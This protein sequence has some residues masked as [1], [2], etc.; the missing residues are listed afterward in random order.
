MDLIVA[1]RW[2]A[3]WV[4]HLIAEGY[5][6]PSAVKAANRGAFLAES[7]YHDVHSLDNLLCDMRGANDRS[8]AA[9]RDLPAFQALAPFRFNT[10]Q[11]IFT[12][13]SSKGKVP[14]K[15]FLRNM[16][17]WA[18]H[19]TDDMPKM[20]HALLGKHKSIAAKWM[21]HY[22]DKI[23][24]ACH[25]QDFI[26]R[27]N[28]EIIKENQLLRVLA[29]TPFDRLSPD[30][31]DIADFYLL[32][33]PII[34]DRVTSVR[35]INNFA[36]ECLALEDSHIKTFLEMRGGSVLMYID[37]TLVGALKMV[38]DP[39]M[40]ALRTIRSSQGAYPLVAGGVYG[41]E[42]HISDFGFGIHRSESF[43]AM[44][45]YGLRLFPL[46]FFRHG[47]DFQNFVG[48]VH[49]IGAVR[50]CLDERYRDKVDDLSFYK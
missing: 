8:H 37:D 34:S 35:R 7:I 38:G 13:L 14:V 44:K 19:V 12:A 15:D 22:Y 43:T 17:Y 3:D 42:S 20:L 1:D 27:L 16:E 32:Q 18:D 33:N 9:M 39:S 21:A 4:N 11:Y 31:Q 24:S 40:L 25:D 36:G 47:G 23:S 10:R 30:L 49:T 46:R 29:S 48:L 26:D 41:V 6:R 2:H 50:D 28:L 45:V 5:H